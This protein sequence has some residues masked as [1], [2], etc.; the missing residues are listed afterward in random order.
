[1]TT[2]TDAVTPGLSRLHPPWSIYRRLDLSSCS[3]WRLSGSRA[4][5]SKRDEETATK[6]GQININPPEYDVLLNTGW[7]HFLFW[8]HLLSRL[9]SRSPSRQ[10]VSPTNRT[11]STTP[12]A[13]L[14]LSR[15]EV[16]PSSYAF[17]STVLQAAEEK[18][19]HVQ[20]F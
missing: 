20:P 9:W 8:C 17:S 18:L 15:G 10:T 5:C 2:T 16:P 7:K 1:M 3:S 14:R 19:S 11:V 13:W 6:Q 4:L 12:S